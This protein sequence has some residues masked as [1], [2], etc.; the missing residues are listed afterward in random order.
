MRK[1]LREYKAAIN[2][3]ASKEELTTISY[4]ALKNDP[5]CTIF[6]KKY[7]RIIEMCI[8]REE[9]LTRSQKDFAVKTPLSDR[10]RA[11]ENQQY[12]KSVPAPT[13]PDHRR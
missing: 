3:A 6:S 10:I 7:E 8:Q 2:K 1:N 5:E 13:P 9:D 4:D 12:M 11:A